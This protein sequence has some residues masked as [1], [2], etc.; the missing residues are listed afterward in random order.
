MWNVWDEMT[1]ILNAEKTG[2]LFWSRHTTSEIFW[3]HVLGGKKNMRVGVC[4]WPLHHS[5]CIRG[6]K[7]IS[8]HS[9]YNW[10]N[11]QLSGGGPSYTRGGSTASAEILL[12]VE[13]LANTLPLDCS[14]LSHHQITSASQPPHQKGS[15][16]N[17]HDHI[18]KFMNYFRG[19]FNYS[20]C[21]SLWIPLYN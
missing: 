11:R 9:A 17:A 5:S 4:M 18:V 16:N 12:E 20:I 21:H 19:H 1:T 8:V 14:L 13:F 15:E 7:N 10:E 2:A 3:G 6:I